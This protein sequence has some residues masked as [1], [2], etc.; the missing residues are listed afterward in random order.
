M[1]EIEILNQE[2]QEKEKNLLNRNDFFIYRD[3]FF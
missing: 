3:I 1:I 2:L